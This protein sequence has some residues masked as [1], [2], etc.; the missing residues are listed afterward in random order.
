[1]FLD[2]HFFS[3]SLGKNCAF[4][5]IVPQRVQNQIGIGSTGGKTRYPVLY[6]L[7][8]LSDD[9]TIW[10]RRTSIERYAA[11]KQVIII[12]PNGD[13]SFYCDMCHGGR[14]WT[15]LSEE[16]PAI[17]NATLPASPDRADT[18]AAGLSMGGYG[19]L[20]LALRRPDLFAA[21]G[22]MSAVTDIGDFLQRMKDAGNEKEALGFFGGWEVPEND[23][24]FRLATAM[25]ARPAAE[26]P[27]IFHACG[28]E[29]FLYTTNTAFRDHMQKLGVCD[30]TYVESPGSHTWAFWDHYIQEILNWLPLS[31]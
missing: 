22:A 2:C 26:R 23:D 8:G 12:M 25:T 11:E 20:K 9:H 1:M 6:L 16:L 4:Y 17:V 27:R 29:D 19:A 10:L 13:R 30:Y 21:A 3:D 14:Y 28:T 5:A 15:F 24:L 18:F 7:H 31:K